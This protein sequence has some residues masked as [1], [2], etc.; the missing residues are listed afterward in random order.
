M[1]AGALNDSMIEG[2]TKLKNE[3]IMKQIAGVPANEGAIQVRDSSSSNSRFEKLSN[4][5][6]LD[7][8]TRPGVD[9][10][11]ADRAMREIERRQKDGTMKV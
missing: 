9:S 10:G 3:E 4:D 8:A 5:Q 1:A 7:A 2:G 11:T 6:L